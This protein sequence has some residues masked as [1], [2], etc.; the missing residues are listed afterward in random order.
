MNAFPRPCKRGA[1][2]AEKELHFWDGCFGVH[3]P[4]RNESKELANDILTNGDSWCNISVYLDKFSCGRESTRRHMGENPDA[5]F[6]GK[7]YESEASPSYTIF[8]EVARVTPKLLPE[9]KFVLLLREPVA[10]A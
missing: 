8:P 5:A 10:R 4:G 2:W 7:M 6:G 3:L 1:R 9:T